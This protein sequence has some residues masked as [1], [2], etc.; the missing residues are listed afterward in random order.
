MT[1]TLKQMRY[2]LALQ[3]HQH[4][5]KAAQA[6]FVTQPALSQ[7]IT[8]LEEHLGWPIFERMGKSVIPT[9]RG[10]QFLI[11]IEQIVRAT[12]DLEEGFVQR[13]DQPN[14]QISMALIP[15]I[16][17]YLL[18]NLL[19]ALNERFA[20]VVFSVGERT[21][22]ELVQAI[23][24]GTC[25]VG[26]LATETNDD[27]LVSKP[28]F[29]D[30]FVLAVAADTKLQAPVDLSKLARDKLLLLSEGHCLRD[31]TM[32]ACQIG[33]E[34]K[35]KTFAA[36]SLS[37]IVE[38]VANKMGMTLLPAISLRRE[39]ASGRV[40]T[41]SLISPGAGRTIYMVWR[42][43]SPLQDLFEQVSDTTM[44]IGKE[45]LIED[46]SDLQPHRDPAAKSAPLSDRQH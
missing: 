45:L 34:L 44:Q 10:T 28:L 33:S 24:D 12:S 16:A 5:G 36:T 15:T 30:P 3:Q 19:P 11:Q 4:F 29:A 43:S 9:P 42:R 7:Q 39:T 14:M 31:Q 35:Q 13:S 2:A 8:L 22:D 41:L 26:L 1:I 23:R 21:T 37:T 17:P 6:S 20:P 25:D 18:P 32:D 27:R 46:A 38:L 40:K